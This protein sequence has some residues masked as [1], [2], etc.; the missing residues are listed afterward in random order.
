MKGI[1]IVNSYAAL[2]E[3]MIEG[4]SEGSTPSS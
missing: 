4:L 1:Q 2:G 3:L